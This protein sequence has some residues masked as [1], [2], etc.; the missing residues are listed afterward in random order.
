VGTIFGREHEPPDRGPEDGV[1][2]VVEAVSSLI[3]GGA[4]LLHYLVTPELERRRD[5]G[6]EMSAMQFDDLLREAPEC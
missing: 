4:A 6:C 1:Y 2:A 3:P 5:D